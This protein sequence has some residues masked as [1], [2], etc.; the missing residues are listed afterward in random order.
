MDRTCNRLFVYGT[1]MSDFPNPMSTHLRSGSRLLGPA[2]ISGNLF[3]LNSYPGAVYD[4]DSDKLI[5]GEL[6][7]LMDP[8]ASFR[9]LDAY[10]NGGTGD[11]PD[12][13]YQRIQVPVICKGKKMMAWMY[14]YSQSTK[15]LE[16]IDSG[17]YRIRN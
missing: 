13:L 4:T 1:L 11:N 15:C 2:F 12:Y 3:D 10:E 9:W 6:Y 5:H 16:R 14:E 7:Q 17:D 8:K